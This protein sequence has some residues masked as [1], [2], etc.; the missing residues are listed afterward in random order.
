MSLTQEE[1][2]KVARLAR[3]ELA[4]EEIELFQAQLSA[5]LDYVAQLQQLDT[6]QIEELA[7]PLPLSNVFRPDQERPSLSVDEA[8]QNAPQRLGDYFAVPAIF[9]P[10]EG[11]ISH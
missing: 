2:R 10:D 9:G 4:E 5:I 7:H 3:L 8:L 6:S 1:V 11:P